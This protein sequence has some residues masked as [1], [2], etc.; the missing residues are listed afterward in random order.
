MDASEQKMSE[1]LADVVASGEIDINNMDRFGCIAVCVMKEGNWSPEIVDS[2]LEQV[3]QFRINLLDLSI[4]DI[5]NYYQGRFNISVCDLLKH[6]NGDTFY[7][8]P[9]RPPG[10][11]SH[12]TDI[13]RHVTSD[14][15][16]TVYVN[17]HVPSEQISS[18]YSKGTFG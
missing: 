3:P 9:L 10:R 11:T 12:A 7:L 1:C 18:I 6:T 15:Q 8:R 17:V 5:R 14:V 16:Y 13:C 4:E 2:V